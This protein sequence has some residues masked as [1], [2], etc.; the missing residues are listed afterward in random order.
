MGKAPVI[1]LA[2][3]CSLLV[4]SS[5]FALGSVE[6]G[7]I[8]ILSFVGILLFWFLIVCLVLAGV[9][10]WVWMF[11]DCLARKDASFADDKAVWIIVL[12]FTSIIGALLYFFF[13]RRR[14]H[15]RDSGIKR[16]KAPGKKVR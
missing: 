7:A 4:A 15:S 16:K 8:F 2:L 11:I 5:V 12:L 10:F 3:L 1:L 9:I 14:L 6:V 13:V